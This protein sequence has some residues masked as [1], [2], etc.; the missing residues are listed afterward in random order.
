MH[1]VLDEASD[2]AAFTPP[3]FRRGRTHTGKFYSTICEDKVAL[4]IGWLLHNKWMEALSILS[5]FSSHVNTHVSDP[6]ISQLMVRVS[7][8][9]LRACA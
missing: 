9:E 3:W 7:Y 2:E 8:S 1:V 5:D 4:C 6:Q